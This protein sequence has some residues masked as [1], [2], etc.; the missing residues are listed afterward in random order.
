VVTARRRNAAFFAAAILVAAA[1]PPQ[2]IVST[3]PS[4][5]EL[6]FAL[7]LGDRVVGVTRY[8]HYPPEALQ[9]PKIGDFINPNLEAIAALRPDLV[10][11][12]S[13]PVRLAE[14]MSALHLKTLEI[15]QDSIQAVYD[16]IRKIGEAT[17]EPQRADKLIAT[18]RS[19][20]DAVRARAAPLPKTRMMFVVGRA[21]QRL[22]Q[23]FVAG[24]ASYLNEVIE[25]AGGKN[26]FDDTVGGYPSVSLEQVIVRKPDVII[27]MGDMSETSGMSEAQKRAV[28]ALWHSG[29]AAGA[30]HLKAVYPVASEIF[31]I[32]GPRVVDAARAFFDMLHPGK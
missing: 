18:I 13:N 11:I 27:D 20:L 22:D 25:I 23:L 5:T 9:K 30:L 21:P 17:G 15:N 32:P 7:G 16:S 10:I 12:Q 2:R 26:V 19:G 29:P 24:R 28:I 1:N 14:R 31:V 4:I 3:T 6:L 8:C